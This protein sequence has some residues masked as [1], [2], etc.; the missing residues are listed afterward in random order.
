MTRSALPQQDWDHGRKLGKLIAKA[1][2]EQR[3]S[4][5]ELA[6]GSSVSIDAVRSLECGRIATPSFLTVARLASSLGL[7]LDELHRQAMRR[8]RSRRSGPR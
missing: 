6:I 4:A 3:K 2:A 1:R 5:S 7:S 8:S